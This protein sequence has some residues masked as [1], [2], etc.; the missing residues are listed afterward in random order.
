MKKMM[1][2]LI[3]LF[4]ASTFNVFAAGVWYRGDITNIIQLDDGRIFIDFEAN[5]TQA[6]FTGVGRGVIESYDTYA[7]N[8]LALALTAFTMKKGISINMDAPPMSAAQPILGITVK[9]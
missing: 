8:K 1:C 2:L 7:K 6:S 3:V 5:G 9:R 4:F